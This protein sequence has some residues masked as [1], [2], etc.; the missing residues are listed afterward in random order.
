MA[1][2]LDM[3]AKFDVSWLSIFQKLTPESSVESSTHVS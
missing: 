2:N 3:R 1:L